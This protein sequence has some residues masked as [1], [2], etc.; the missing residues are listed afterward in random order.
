RTLRVPSAY[1]SVQAAVDASRPGDTVLIARGLYHEA[2]TVG[3]SHRGITIRGVDRNTVILD[4]DSGS[5]ITGI[6]VHADAV[7]VENLTI[8]RYAVNGLVFAPPAAA[9]DD[10][11][12]YGTTSTS[13]GSPATLSG[14][15]GS[16]ITAYDNGLYGVYAFQARGGSFDHVYASGQPDSGIYVGQ[17]RPCDAT[18]TA[19]VAVDDAV[20][21]EDTDATGVTVRGVVLRA[22]RIGALLDSDIKERMAPQARVTLTASTLAGNDNARAPTGDQGFGAGVVISGGDDDLIDDDRIAGQPLG[23]VVADAP[24]QAGGFQATDNRVLDDRL[25]SSSLDLDLLTGAVSQGNCFAGDHP[26]ATFPARIERVT[27]CGRSVAL[28]GT[29]R[30][31]PANPPPVDYLDVPAPPPQ[32]SM[33]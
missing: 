17:C 8:R 3:P 11:D 22:N 19:S 25:S 15:R 9:S 21:Y 33:P 23:V 2:V 12:E 20:G 1:R 29:P 30:A 14:W 32:P 5:L 24:P 4:G 18:V 6:T 13:A 26:R 7:T 31:L 27:A 10:D 28:R 16:Y